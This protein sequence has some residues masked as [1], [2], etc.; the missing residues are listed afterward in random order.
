M[1]T[2]GS[3]VVATS[4]CTLP[5]NFFTS[6]CI[7]AMCSG[8]SSVASSSESFLNLSANSILPLSFVR[9]AA[10]AYEMPSG[11]LSAN[12]EARR[13]TAAMASALSASPA[14]NF[15]CE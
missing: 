4:D 10:P 14:A 7:A 13:A 15:T 1:P 8:L 11:F 9:S 6:A 12:C 5:S 3:N 2:S